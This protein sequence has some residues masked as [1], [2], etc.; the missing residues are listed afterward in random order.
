MDRNNLQADIADQADPENPVTFYFYTANIKNGFNSG[1]DLSLNY[2]LSKKINLFLNC[3]LLRTGKDAFSY[4][5]PVFGEVPIKEREQARSPKYTLSSGFEVWLTKKIFTRFELLQKDRYYYFNNTDQ[6]A[7]NHTL[8]NISSRCE[9]NKK[10]SINLSIKNITDE[11]YGIHGFY[12]SVSGYAIEGRKFHETLANPR[13]ISL[14][15]S[16]SL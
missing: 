15:L 5:S 16:Y 6:M 12:F 2:N 10:L 1:I 9:I 7:R 8:I 4:P 3:G 13:D 14:S 11:R